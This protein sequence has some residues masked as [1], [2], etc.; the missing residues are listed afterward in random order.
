MKRVRASA[1]IELTFWWEIN[2]TNKHFVHQ[3]V[4]SAVE[5]IK[6]RKGDGECYYI[7]CWGFAVLYGI[8]KVTFKQ[9]SER[10]KE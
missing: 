5:K 9:R 3:S 7:V 10:V 4:V 2:T 1:T 6:A 8:V